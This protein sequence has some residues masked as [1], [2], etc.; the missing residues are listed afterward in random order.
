MLQSVFVDNVDNVFERWFNDPKQ[1]TNT[2]GEQTMSETFDALEFAKFCALVV[3]D[4]GNTESLCWDHWQNLHDT[5]DEHGITCH[6]TRSDAEAA[7]WFTLGRRS[8]DIWI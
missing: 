6:A 2:N 4:Q 7:F 1:R 3:I 8:D 5:L